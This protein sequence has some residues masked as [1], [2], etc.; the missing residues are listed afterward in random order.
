ALPSGH[1]GSAAAPLSQG[2]RQT[3]APRSHTRAMILAAAALLVGVIALLQLHSHRRASSDA[4]A[5][6]APTAG[7]VQ[8]PA[9][10]PTIPV[11]KTSPAHHNPAGAPTAAVPVQANSLATPSHSG[12]VKQVLPKVLPAAQ[13][14]IQGKVNVVVTVHVDAAGRVS[15]AEVTSPGPSR[16]FARIS[17][18]AAQQWL[19][20]PAEDGGPTEPR[21]WNLHFQY[22]QDGVEVMPAPAAR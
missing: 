8:A 15:G 14:S 4:D 5:S 9:T 11:A 21:T 2:R 18:E 6:A 7:D 12:V 22:R 19:F 13:A 16:Y 10:T 17:Q 3:V 20:A 1:H